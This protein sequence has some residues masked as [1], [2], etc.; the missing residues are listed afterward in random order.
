V[1]LP[2][3]HQ[4]RPRESIDCLGEPVNSLREPVNS[5]WEPVNSLQEPV[6]SFGEPVNGLREPVNSIEERA[7]LLAGRVFAAPTPTPTVILR[8]PLRLRSGQA[9]A[10][11]RCSVC[12]YAATPAH[13]SGLRDAIEAQVVERCGD[14]MQVAAVAQ[15]S[16]AMK[17]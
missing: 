14:D 16:T 13:E 1:I 17:A 8:L 3:P 10:V 12:G 15:V 5:L 7:L 9:F 4:L 11:L 2:H 6:N